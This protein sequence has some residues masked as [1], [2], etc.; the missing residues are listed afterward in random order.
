MGQPAHRAARGRVPPGRTRQRLAFPSARM[1]SRAAPVWGA[2]S[3]EPT[4]RGWARAARN[5][6]SGERAFPKFP[7][8]LINSGARLSPPRW[9]SLYP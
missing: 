6:D 3:G 4:E 8:N 7:S 2:C 5:L 1:L 9:S